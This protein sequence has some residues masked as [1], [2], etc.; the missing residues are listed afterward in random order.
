ME[1]FAWVFCLKFY[2]YFLPGVEIAQSVYQWATGWKARVRFPAMQD[3][4]LRFKIQID[5]GTQPA[6]YPM[7]ISGYLP[8][9]GTAEP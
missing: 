7:G 1:T 8:G 9:S 5:S 6:S 4:P 2:T 3:F